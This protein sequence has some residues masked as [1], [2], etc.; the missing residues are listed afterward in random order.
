M[1]SNDPQ[2]QGQGTTQ[3]TDE[4]SAST[5]QGTPDTANAATSGDWGVSN[6]TP[7]VTDWGISNPTVGDWGTANPDGTDTGT[8]AGTDPLPNPG[9]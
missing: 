1:A 4:A 6:P 5:D 2:N 9:R 8:N 7:D 3:S